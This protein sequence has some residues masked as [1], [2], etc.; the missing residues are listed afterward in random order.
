MFPEAFNMDPAEVRE[1]ALKCALRRPHD[2]PRELLKYWRFRESLFSRYSEG[3]LLDE[4]SWFSVTPE[5]IAYRLAVKCACDVVMDATC[6][7]GGNVIQFA[8]TCKHG[9]EMR[10][11]ERAL[12]QQWW[13]W[14][15]T[16]SSWSWPSIMV[17]RLCCHT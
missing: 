17:R 10:A 8:M 9:M 3:I 13:L 16:Q 4:E 2:M 1:R 7:A 5:A 12:T 11:D 6:G 15:L 14:I